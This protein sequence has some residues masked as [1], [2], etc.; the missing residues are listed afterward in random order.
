MI[1]IYRF[2][3]FRL[4]LLLPIFQIIEIETQAKMPAA[5]SRHKRVAVQ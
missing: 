1:D 5:L 3:N 4:C 2:I